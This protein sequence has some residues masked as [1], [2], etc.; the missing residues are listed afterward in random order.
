[1]KWSIAVYRFVRQT[2]VLL[3]RALNIVLDFFEKKPM[4]Q[5]PAIEPGMS[6][7]DEN[8]F[9]L[10]CIENGMKTLI[11]NHILKIPISWGKERFALDE[12]IN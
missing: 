9:D 3:D 10:P 5:L 4:T 8:D 1:M 6:G 12:Y 7:K 2:F 11:R